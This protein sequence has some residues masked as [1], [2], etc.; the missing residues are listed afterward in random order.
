MNQPLRVGLVGAGFVTQYHLAAWARL[1]D[2]AKVV[3]IADPST[4][5]A[6][7]RAAAFGIPHVFSSAAQMIER[8]QLDA[9]DVAAPREYHAEV[10]LLAAD[11]EL[12]VLCQKPLAPTYNQ[13]R[14]LAAYVEG[15]IRLMVH[16]NWRFRPYYRELAKWLREGRIGDVV[17]AQMTLLSSGLLPDENGELPMIVRQPFIAK[18][19]RALVMEVLI[20]HIDTLRFLLGELQLR[21]AR[22]GHASPAIRGEDRAFLAFETGQG[23]PVALLSNVAVHGQ[24]ASLIDRLI[25]IGTRGTITLSGDT[26][27]CVGDAPARLTYDMPACYSQSYADTLAHFVECLRT[28]APFETA[29]EDNL[30]TLE[31]VEAAYTMG[32]KR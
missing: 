16:E 27:R 13:A 17:Q 21:Y 23:A 26:L 9:I 18:L 2:Q 4:N 28:G 24:P 20:H 22:L 30:R 12:P 5:A 11:H 19:D 31:L 14:G 32:N 29:P 6:K 8:A 25:V 10:V 3:A 15:R 1:G 7:S